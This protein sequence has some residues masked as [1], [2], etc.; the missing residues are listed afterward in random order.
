MYSGVPRRCTCTSR[1]RATH[2]RRRTPRSRHDEGP[3][4]PGP[5]SL[6]SSTSKTLPGSMSC[7]LSDTIRSSC[8]MAKTHERPITCCTAP[9]HHLRAQ[10]P[11]MTDVSPSCP[12]ALGAYLGHFVLLAL[13]VDH[14]KLG[15][16]PLLQL[17]VRPVGDVVEDPGLPG[18]LISLI[19]NTNTFHVSGH[20]T[21]GSRTSE[22]VPAAYRG[23]G[24]LRLCRGSSRGAR[25]VNT[26]TPC[27]PSSTAACRHQIRAGDGC[28]SC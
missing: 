4:T 2:V 28:C 21:S 19:H 8:H 24:R 15:L 9:E 3:K 27:T 23:R 11:S 25:K 7:T 14:S 12:A 20:T 5:N 1:H 6:T 22:M 10:Q 13:D 17:H 16:Q 26:G 18:P